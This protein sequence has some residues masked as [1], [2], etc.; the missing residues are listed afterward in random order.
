MA[1]PCVLGVI[2][3][4]WLFLFSHLLSRSVFFLTNFLYEYVCD[5]CNKCLVI[6][7]FMASWSSLHSSE[8]ASV[9]EKGQSCWVMALPSCCNALMTAAVGFIPQTEAACFKG[10]ILL[11]G[12]FPFTAW[13]FWSPVPCN[14]YLCLVPSLSHLS[15]QTPVILLALV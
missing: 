14:S 15:H 6:I 3:K 7:C 10:L 5:I 13:A 4:P 9:S 8:A 1:S 11:D 12:E 2:L